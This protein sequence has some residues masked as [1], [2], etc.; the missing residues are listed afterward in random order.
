MGNL[1]WQMVEDLDR[2]PVRQKQTKIQNR[3]LASKPFVRSLV[4]FPA[5]LAS[6][7]FPNQIKIYEK[8]LR[9]ICLRT[10]SFLHFFHGRA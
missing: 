2:A 6:K 10:G 1:K 9:Y 7:K 4:L 8:F 3:V 5:I